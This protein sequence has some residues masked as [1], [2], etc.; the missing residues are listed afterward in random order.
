M[1]NPF[2]YETIQ[3][4]FTVKQLSQ[5]GQGRHY[6]VSFPIAFPGLYQESNTAEGEYFQANRMHKLPLVILIHGWGDHSAIPLH[7]MA[8]QLS[9]KGMHCFVL[10]LPF[11]TRRLP[12]EMK[13][14]S[15]N[16]TQEEWF[17]GYRIA[18]TDVRQILDWAK[19]RDEIDK[20][21]VAVVGL[22]LGSFVG[23]ITMGIDDRINAGVFIVSGGNSAKIQEHSRFARFRKQYRFEPKDYEDYQQSYGQYLQDVT[24]KG[25]ENVEPARRVFLIDPLTYAYRLKGRPVLLLNAWWDEFIPRETTLELH[26]ACGECELNWYPTT[27]ASIWLFYPSIAGR[28]YRFLRNSFK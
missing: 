9:N 26:K 7:V 22:S 2:K 14:R 15:P 19:T 13:K 12:K 16:F 20:D 23:S 27:H 10:Y 6:S 1:N 4:H 11:H 18:I 5:G 17:D 21:R 8:R 24:L 28:V 3:P 25:W